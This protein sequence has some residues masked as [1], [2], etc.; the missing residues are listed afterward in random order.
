MRLLIFLR[1]FVATH[2]TTL[3]LVR[4]Y[5]IVYYFEVFLWRRT[6]RLLV[7]CVAMRL[8]IFLRDSLWR[9]TLRLMTIF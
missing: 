9:R 4:R 3:G 1:F 2:P 6:L 5:E 8:L 7:W